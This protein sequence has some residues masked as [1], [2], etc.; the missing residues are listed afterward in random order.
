MHAKHVA[1]HEMSH[2][3][4]FSLIGISVGASTQFINMHMAGVLQAVQ[5]DQCRMQTNCKR[6]QN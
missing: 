3:K 1:L 2:S 5:K 6:L 4:V